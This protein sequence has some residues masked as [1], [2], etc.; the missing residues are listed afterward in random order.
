MVWDVPQGRSVEKLPKIRQ[1]Y[2]PSAPARGQG[3]PGSGQEKNALHATSAK[4]NAVGVLG[5][6]ETATGT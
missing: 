5:V 3:G 1:E 2:V 6:D 4:R